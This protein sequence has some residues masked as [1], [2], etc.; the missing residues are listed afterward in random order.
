MEY[1]KPVA[2]PSVVDSA[3]IA[4]TANNVSFTRVL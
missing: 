4:F 2:R 3:F 1:G